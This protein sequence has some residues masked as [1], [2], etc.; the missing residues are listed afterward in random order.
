MSTTLERMSKNGAHASFA[1][2]TLGGTRTYAHVMQSAHD[3]PPSRDVKDLSWE[4]GE[5]LSAEQQALH[6][7]IE[8]INAWAVEHPE[9][10][11]GVWLDN[12]G[13]LNGTGPVRIGVGLAAREQYDA[14]S[15]LAALVD[16]PTRLVVV[17]KAFPE[18]VLRAAQER[19]VARWMSSGPAGHHR[20]AGCGVDTHANALEVMLREPDEGLGKR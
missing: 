12:S 9:S 5:R 13:F 4:E 6:P 7:S 16:D 10:F 8:R 14:T 1:K 18:A 15:D 2:D 19:V 20:V 17:D 11:A 3:G